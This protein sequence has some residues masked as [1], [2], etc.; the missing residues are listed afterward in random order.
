[1]GFD[2]DVAVVGCG[3]VGAAAGNL[4][5]AQ[6][7][8]V[9][10]LEAGEEPYD[11]P[12][13]IHFD[14]EI[15]RLFQS[16]GIADLILPCL[17]VPAATVHVGAD[18]GVIRQWRPV[19]LAPHLGW[20]S[21]YFFYQ[22]D[23]E[24]ALRAGLAR[25]PLVTTLFGHR[26]D[27]IEDR[28]DR[29][30]LTAREGGA[31]RQFEAP[32]A[33]GC[34]GASSVVR[35]ALGIGLASM[36]FDE[37]W[38]VIDANVDGPISFPSFHGLPAEADLQRTLVMVGDPAR[39]LTVI[40][41]KGRHRRWECMLLPEENEESVDAAFIDGLLRPWLG[42]SR[43]E[44][45]R[46]AVYRFHAL[47]ADSWREGR[48]F[49][50]GDSAH[51]TPPFYGQGLC[52]GIRD[53]GNLAWKL[54]AVLDGR[55]G[56]ALLESYETERR[57]QV[58]A[59]MRA[60]IATGRYICTLD[61][62]AARLR[63]DRMRAV[64]QATAPVPVDIIPPLADGLRHGDGSGAGMRFIQ[65]RVAFGGTEAL[66]DDITGGGFVLLTRDLASDQVEAAS[67]PLARFR[68]AIFSVGGPEGIVDL[69]GE[70]GRWFDR[71]QCEAVVI[72]PDFYV[73]AT[74]RTGDELAAACQSLAAMMIDG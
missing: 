26:I 70:L 38:V 40:P 16:A 71:Q 49:L 31:I 13:A 74:A 5:A 11:L 10:I 20:A 52:H 24:K 43:C 66:L 12:R 59:V 15:M 62:D 30:V 57:P 28:A 1:M 18:H 61:P 39:P 50:A 8:R 56:P 53:V 46:A 14:H 34:D 35:K 41:G 3:P 48:I 33:I 73:F 42:T 6:G 47:V 64:A 25:N 67:A 27:A 44:V 65:P 69:T 45:I 63:D 22:P 60:S 58:E 23:L 2:F 21:D 68:P 72:R 54:A 37:P 4:L 19:S 29:V 9:L 7:L 55:A 36:D 17:T 51:Q 32:F